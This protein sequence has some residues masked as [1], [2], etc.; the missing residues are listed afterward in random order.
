MRMGKRIRDLR[1]K[2]NMSLKELAQRTDLSI[3]YLSQIERNLLTPSLGSLVKISQA[4]KI[5]V[6][7]LF[8]EE[9][10]PSNPIIKKNQRKKIAVPN[11]HVVYELVSPRQAVVEVLLAKIEPRQGEDDELVTHEGEECVY[12]IKGTL[13][14]RLGEKTHT[15]EEGDSIFFQS[16]TP[17]R[18]NNPANTSSVML[19]AHYPPSF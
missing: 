13:E 8:L 18:F 5:P 4:L 11:S 6:L 10:L 2:K 19:V 9:P 12:V 14:V 16:T 1:K 17:H 7:W 3:G 15:V